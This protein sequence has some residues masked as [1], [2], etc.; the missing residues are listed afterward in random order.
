MPNTLVP[1]MI[2]LAAL[3]GVL[4]QIYSFFLLAG[5]LAALGS[6][7]SRRFWAGLLILMVFFVFPGVI[8]PLALV[9]PVGAFSNALSVTAMHSLHS[10]CVGSVSAVAE[11]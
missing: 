5:L 10:K 1:A 2:A 3:G 6:I 8:V 4:N 9:E 7:R 11:L